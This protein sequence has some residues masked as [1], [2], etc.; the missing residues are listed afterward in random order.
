MTETK[1][2]SIG[3]CGVGV[4]SRGWCNMHYRRWQTHGDPLK[5]RIAKSECSIEGCGTSGKITRGWCVTH[6]TRWRKTGD[7][8]GLRG[9]KQKAFCEIEGCTA[10]SYGHGWCS[11][12]YGRWK[13]TG[14]PT[15]MSGKKRPSFATPEEAFAHWAR[16]NG[17]CIE[18]AGSTDAAGYGRITVEGRRVRAH[19]YAWGRAN[20]PIPEGMVIDHRCINPSCVNVDHL[21]AVTVGQNVRA[22]SA[23]GREGAAFRGIRQ[24]TSGRWQARVG[25]DGKSFAVTVDTEEEARA[26]VHAMWV[27]HYGEEFVANDWER[28]VT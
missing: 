24:R 3:G 15:K 22:Q 11:K 27:K 6:Y 26:A 7:P 9:R 25:S 17:D 14:D 13:R 12:H 28:V 4:A 21:R 23:L 1:T 18:W 16:R 20:G 10:V 19:R 8:L 5:I 2:C